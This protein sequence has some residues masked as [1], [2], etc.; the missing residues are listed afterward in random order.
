MI[1]GSLAEPAVHL[2]L[3]GPGELFVRFPFLLP[4]LCSATANSC[5]FVASFFLLDETNRAKI[6]GTPEQEAVPPQAS[7]YTE[8]DHYCQARRPLRSGCWRKTKIA[9]S[10]RLQ[11]DG[12]LRDL[13]MFQ[14]ASSKLK[15]LFSSVHCKLYLLAFDCRQLEPNPILPTTS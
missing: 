8:N 14:I 15:H 11:Q 13:K 7:Q 10:R 4:C 6:T 2:G 9:R 12:R 5:A 1:G 3:R